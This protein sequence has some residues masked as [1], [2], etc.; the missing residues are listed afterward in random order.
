MKS[1]NTCGLKQE[2]LKALAEIKFKTP[3]PIQAKAI[4]LV[5]NLT[6]FQKHIKKYRK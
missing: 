1:F 4:P 2:I 5:H 6:L 3:T